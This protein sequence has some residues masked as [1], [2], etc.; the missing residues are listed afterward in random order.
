M[1]NKLSYQFP[2]SRFLGETIMMLESSWLYQEGVLKQKSNIWGFEYE[3]FSTPSKFRFLK[4]RYDYA[5]ILLFSLVCPK[6]I[7]PFNINKT[8]PSMPL[9][10]QSTPLTIS[11]LSLDF[12][13]FT[14]KITVSFSGLA[15]SCCVAFCLISST[16]FQ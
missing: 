1:T 2:P 4:K 13:P 9:C 14:K 15:I 11:H 8:S 5:W 12:F 7:L 3:H 16:I 6:K 10:L